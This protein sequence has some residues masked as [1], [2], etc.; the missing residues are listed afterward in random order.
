MNGCRGIKEIVK[1]RRFIARVSLFIVILL[2]ILC[3]IEYNLS[4]VVNSHNK[5]RTHLERQ[6]DSIEIFVLGDSHARYGVDPTVFSPKG[7]NLARTFSS[8][9]VV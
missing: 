2:G 3:Y 1:M 6:L 5:Q 7:F 4:F 9:R 8:A